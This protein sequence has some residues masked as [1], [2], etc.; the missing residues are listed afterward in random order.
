MYNLQLPSASESF[1]FPESIRSDAFDSVLCSGVMCSYSSWGM[2]VDEFR[3]CDVISGA[4]PPAK[5]AFQT[6]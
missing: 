5:E 4:D 3:V 6:S 2:D 1:C